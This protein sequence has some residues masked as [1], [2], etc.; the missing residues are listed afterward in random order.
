MYSVIRSFGLNGLNGF[1]VAV[2][3]DVSGGMPALSIVGLPDSAVRESGDRVHAAARNL[4]FKWPDRRITVNLAPADVRKTGPVYDL[5]LLLAV[6]SSAGQIEPPPEEAAFLGE[7]ALDGSLRPVSGVLPMALT[8]AASGVQAL[9]VPAENAA[10]AAEACGDTMLVY[11]AHTALEVVDAL[12]GI[13]PISPIRCAPFDPTDAWNAAPD[14]ADV[15]GQPLARRAMVLAAAG[16]HNVLLIGA[17]G[18]GKSMLAKRLPG[19]LPPLTR[20]EAVE[21]TKIYS[22]AGQLPKGRGLI[23]A[24][25]FRSPHHSASAAALAGGGTTFRPGECSLADCGVLF[26]DELPEFSRD[27]LEVLRQPLEDGQI[28]VS[29]AAGSATYPSRFQLVAAM[30]PC[31]CGYYGHPTRPCTCSPSA[32]RQYRSRVSG[33]L[34]D[35]IDLCVEMDPVAFDELHGTASAESSADLRRQVLFARQVQAKR[36]AAPGFEGVHCNARLTA[37][38]VRRVCRMTPAAERLLRA[39]YETLGLS[40]RAHDRILRVARTVA[41]LAGKQLL[42]EDSLLEALQYRAQEKVEL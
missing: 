29:R 39:S 15:M 25:P 37:G 4:G 13:R 6:L 8:A 9:Y 27:S 23:S 20:E 35:R 18:T 17:P 3:A 22:I 7:L 30:N 11:P 40:A 1:A 16:G 2:E 12:R 5:P 19:I 10:E 34:L 33:P 41:D 21:T 24:R 42:D 31:K 28:T 38:Q 14:F 32:V 36:Y 26:L